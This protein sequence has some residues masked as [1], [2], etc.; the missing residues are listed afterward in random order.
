[1]GKTTY[2]LSLIKNAK[3]VIVRDPRGE[4]GRLPGFDTVNTLEQLARWCKDKSTKNGKVS[5]FGS[6]KDFS[7]FC[8]IAYTWSQEKESVIIAE[9]LADVSNS[10]KATGFWGELIRKGLYYGSFIVAIAQRAQEIDNTLRGNATVIH[11]HGY[12]LPL[13]CEFMGNLLGVEPERINNLK[14]GEYLERWQGDKEIKKGKT[15][16]K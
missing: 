7:G 9:E 5:F 1:M 15:S 13:D 14:V 6:A 8:E 12:M 4:Y 10:G 16:S 2:V 11:T 3:R